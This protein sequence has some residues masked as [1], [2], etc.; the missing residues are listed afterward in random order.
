MVS[1]LKNRPIEK[2]IKDFKELE[3]T[4]ILGAI[5][6]GDVEE[7]DF[8][9]IDKDL[10]E[11]AL[12][13]ESKLQTQ[14]TAEVIKP[15]RFEVIDHRTN[16]PDIGRLSPD[17]YEFQYQD[18]GK[19]LKVFLKDTAEV[20]PSCDVVAKIDKLIY[21][22][23]D[24]VEPD[25]YREQAT[26]PYGIINDVVDVFIECK[27][28]QQKPKDVELVERINKLYPRLKERV[29]YFPD[30]EYNNLML[31]IRKLLTKGK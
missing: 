15:T 30:D 16:A 9:Q 25:S 31:D 4:N 14:P 8:A 29:S 27:A 28:L 13:A 11:L 10:K 17:A 23:L 21:E 7:K 12:F 6:S 24:R 2:I 1:E 19:T 5:D 20:E 26:I 3:F 18:D 22:L